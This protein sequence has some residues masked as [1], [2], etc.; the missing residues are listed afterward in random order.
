MGNNKPRSAGPLT[1]EEILSS[2]K[3]SGFPLE[4]R[5]LQAFDE[6]GFD[7]TPPHR[8][9]LGEGDKER[10]AEID[11]TARAMESLA[12]H[13]GLLLLTL[14]IEAKQIDE[15]VT[16]VG[17]KWKQPPPLEMRAARI[18]FSGLPT[19]NVLRNGVDGGR[20]HQFLLGGEKPA[21]A[22]LDGLNEA[23][24][25]HHWC[26][27]R[28][29]SKREW[30]EATQE[31]DMRLSFRK[32]VHATTWLER[33]SALQFLRHPGDPPQWRL[34]IIFPTIVIATPQLYTFD[35]LTNKL[36]KTQSLILREMY[37]VG[38]EVHAR[39]VD[40]VTENEIP[41]LMLRHRDAARA[42]R[43]AC[44]EGAGE[45]SRIVDEQRLRQ[46]KLDRET[47]EKDS[48]RHG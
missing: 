27:V 44:D 10:S 7:P 39:Y 43:K 13:R 38:G 2:L 31:D 35:A 3:R 33:E 24:L 29:N 8:F 28:D 48:L 20:F 47:A 11:V 19:C 23:P 34:Q 1:E 45:L 30:I 9:I 25:C 36:E 16:F 5:L 41:N 32:L 17:F 22:A 6:G 40:V 21:M 15:R 26:F 12:G 14:M 46:E 4:I 42:L 37:E 18:R